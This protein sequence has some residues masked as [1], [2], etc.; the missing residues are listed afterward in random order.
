[1]QISWQQVKHTKLYSDL[2]HFQALENLPFQKVFCPRG[3]RDGN[4]NL[5]SKIMFRNASSIS[6]LHVVSLV[7]I[8]GT[9]LYIYFLKTRKNK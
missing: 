5:K 3:K 2:F 4:H 6:Q 9:G 8:N 7:T 1:M